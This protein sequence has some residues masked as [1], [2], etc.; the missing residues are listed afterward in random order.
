MPVPTNIA[1]AYVGLAYGI[2]A[3]V[4]G[5]VDGYGGPTE[6]AEP[7]QRTLSELR[8]EADVLD[9]LV[10][11]VDDPA[12]RHFLTVQVRAMQ[13]VLRLTA[14]EKLSHFDEVR[15]LYE[16][17]PVYE[18]DQVLQAA[19]ADLDTALPGAGTLSERREALRHRLRLSEANVLR[20]AQPIVAELRHR[21]C[22]QIELPAGEEFS[23]RLVRD[24]PWG[25]YN[26]P[27]GDFRSRIDINVD[28]PVLLQGLVD[29]L[30]HEGYPGHH[31]EHALKEHRLA[32]EKGWQ[33][34]GLHL[35]RAPECVVS[36]GIAVNALE[37]VVTPEE[38]HDCMTGELCTEAGLDKSDVAAWIQVSKA[39][40][41]L[42][43]LS[44]NAAYLLHQEGRTQAEV[45]DY[46]LTHGALTAEQAQQRLDAVQRPSSRAYV[47]TYAVGGRLVRESMRGPD[48]AAVFRDLLTQPITPGKLAAGARSSDRQSLRSS[49]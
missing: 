38:L 44:G 40:K 14:G 3:Y 10:G 5:F 26:W 23:I 37:A 35:S 32:R 2:E 18:S 17:D 12:R 28:V 16:I 31:T 49:Q 43:G 15:G 39:Q 6:W 47:Y 22:S 20:L 13:T 46:L 1:A 42:V 29:L 21:T 19:L 30:A 4:P 33:E 9:G 41:G 25:G 34:F 27:L 48:R 11:S 45:L 8:A 24:K 36:E 7:R